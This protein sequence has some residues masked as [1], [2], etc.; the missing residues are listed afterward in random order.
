MCVAEYVRRRQDLRTGTEGLA[1]IFH[2]R[3]LTAYP[4]KQRR[5]YGPI[6]PRF[7]GTRFFDLGRDARFMCPGFSPRKALHRN[8]CASLRE[9]VGGCARVGGWEAVAIYGQHGKD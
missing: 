7:V 8:S 1:G 4:A 2:V 9:G 6:V 3:S 5:P